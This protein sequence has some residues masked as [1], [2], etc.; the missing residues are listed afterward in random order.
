MSASAEAI[1]CD[2]HPAVPGMAALAPY[3]DD[4]WRRSVEERGIE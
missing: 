3:L 2:V 1:D 4:H